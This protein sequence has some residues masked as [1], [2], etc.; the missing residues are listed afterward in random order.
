M[1]SGR[2]DGRFGSTPNASQISES[3]TFGSDTF[4]C[5]F[6]DLHLAF[7]LTSI[8][9]AVFIHYCK[10]RLYIQFQNLPYRLSTS[11]SNQNDLSSPG[12]HSSVPPHLRLLFQRIYSAPIHHHRRHIAYLSALL[13]GRCLIL[14]NPHF[15]L[16][17]P[18]PADPEVPPLA[19]C[20]RKRLLPRFRLR[21]FQNRHQN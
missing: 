17:V 12:Q 14:Q 6:S 4:G 3:H 8:F 11:C 5:I 2:S 13:T 19:P 21:R 1:F 7:N 10:T 18:P 20:L 9:Y 16:D 15:Q